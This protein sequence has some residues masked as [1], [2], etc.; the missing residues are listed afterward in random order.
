VLIGTNDFWISTVIVF[1][2]VSHVVYLSLLTLTVLARDS[3]LLSE[4][5]ECIKDSSLVHWHA[6][7]FTGC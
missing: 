5:R 2:H 7:L 6:L 3:F 1:K 4:N